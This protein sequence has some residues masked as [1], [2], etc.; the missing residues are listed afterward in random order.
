[1]GVD[2]AGMG[3]M[4]MTDTERLSDAIK[5]G[6]LIVPFRNVGLRNLWFRHCKTTQQ[7]YVVI[8]PAQK[9]SQV[10]MDLIGQEYDLHPIAALEIL[11]MLNT[12]HSECGGPSDGHSATM[13]FGKV[14][15]DLGEV[16][17]TS[18]VALA[19]NPKFQVPLG[20]T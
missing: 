19:S 16:I 9:Y 17:A 7:P 11:T 12:H 14:P 5:T 6:Y 20:E 3:A 15:R 8:Y 13:L 10:D 18:M 4:S 2:V 1:M